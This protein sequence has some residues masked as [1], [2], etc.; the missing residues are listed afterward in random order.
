M[1]E[2]SEGL[3]L[4]RLTNVIALLTKLDLP[5]VCLTVQPELHAAEAAGEG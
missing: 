2:P 4:C 3:Q 1:S 5:E